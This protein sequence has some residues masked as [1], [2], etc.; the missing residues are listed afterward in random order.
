MRVYGL[1]VWVR[2]TA[3]R[4]L[5]KYLDEAQRS[6][7]TDGASRPRA[8]QA[9]GSDGGAKPS[10][11]GAHPSSS[12]ARSAVGVSIA[13]E[14]EL[15]PRELGGKA[16]MTATACMGLAVVAAVYLFGYCGAF[17]PPMAPPSAAPASR[18]NPLA[19]RMVAAP[20]DERFGR[21]E[22]ATFSA[23]AV[24]AAFPLSGAC[25]PRVLH[26]CMRSCACLC[27]TLAPD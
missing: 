3:G 22:I 12:A 18:A 6:G 16:V 14:R 7:G 15:V 9:T 10:V 20:R 27:A 5:F 1:G 25:C 26:V 21:R 8:R 19:L 2:A 17:A 24:A 23:V 4:H 11:S 13:S